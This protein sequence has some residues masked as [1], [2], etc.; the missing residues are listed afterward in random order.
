[1]CWAESREQRAVVCQ[2]G[3]LVT[4]HRY[5]SDAALVCHCWVGLLVWFRLGDWC[6]LGYVT[7]VV[8]DRL[9][10]WVRLGYWCGLG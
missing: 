2:E 6:G 10:V 8:S 7:G 4:C 1:M 3:E 5:S 9:L